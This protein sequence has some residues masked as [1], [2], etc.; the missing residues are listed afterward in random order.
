LTKP[1]RY[2]PFDLVTKVAAVTLV[3]DD[4]SLFEFHAFHPAFRLWLS[5]GEDNELKS[6]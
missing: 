3:K 6:R 4:L 2:T 5:F 1:K